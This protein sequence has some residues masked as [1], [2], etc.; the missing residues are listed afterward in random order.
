M[1]VGNCKMILIFFNPKYIVGT[2]VNRLNRA[3]KNMFT[4]FMYCQM[5]SK[6]IAILRS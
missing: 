1:R 4:V 2:Q 3:P 6:I 5:D